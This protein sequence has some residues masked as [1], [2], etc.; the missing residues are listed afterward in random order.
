TASTFA[1]IL[2]SRNFR[3]YLTGQTVSMAGTWMQSV[4][5]GWLVLQ[6]TGSGTMLGLVTAT[7]FLPVLL[8]GPFGGVV[9]DRFDTR[10][11]L[12]MTQ[13]AAGALATL[14]G[15]LTIT[16]VVQVWMVFVL[17]VLLGVVTVVDNPARQTIVLELVGRDLL[18]NA[19]TLNSVNV[20][21]A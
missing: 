14:L 17:A 21:A 7:Q 13:L 16:G 19:I 8:V 11:L 20:N 6:L 1:S 4:A 10:R 3:L 15:V 9:V 2:H 5:Q 12:T 18:S